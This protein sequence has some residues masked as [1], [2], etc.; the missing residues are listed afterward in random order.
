MI[1]TFN[2]NNLKAIVMYSLLAFLISCNKKDKYDPISSFDQLEKYFKTTLEQTSKALDEINNATTIEEKKEKYLEARTY[3]KSCEPLL[4]FIDSESYTYLN[5]P[6]L[7]KVEEEDFTDIKIK[8][9]TG[10]QVI[11]ENLFGE[12]IDTIALKKN[13][14]LTSNRIKFLH[15]NQHLQSLKKHHVLWII[16]DAIN[17]VALTGITG[18]DSPVLENSLTESA[19]VYKSLKEILSY[20]ENDFKDK[21]LYIAWVNQLD[22][23][24]T[25]LNNASFEKFNRFIF[26]KENTHQS[27]SL[28][29]KIVKDWKVEFPFKKAINTEASNLF[30]DKTFNINYFTD[31]K[32]NPVQESKVAL[33]KMLFN[34]SSLSNDKSISCATCH[35][36][37]M[38]FTD[39]L[40]VSPK[41]TRNS[42]TLFYAALQKGFFHDKRTGSLEGQIVDVVNNP[43]EFHL[44]LNDLEKRVMAK[45]AYQEAFKKVYTKT[46][47]NQLIR[48]AI[49]SYIMS[50]SPFNSKFDNNMQGKEN[51][52]TQSEINGFNV[53][54]GKAKCATC[55]FAPI[56]NGLIPMAFKESELELIG[57]PD[58]KDT[59]NAIIDDDLGRYGV[60]K[61]QQKKHFFKT[62]T[63]RNI[64]KT[65][66]YMHN[67]VY[68][69]LEEVIEFYNKGG[70]SGLGIELEYQTLPTDK[71]N[72][73]NQEKKDLIAF[74]KSLTD[75]I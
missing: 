58:S 53:F 26:I 6:N 14:D 4:A 62:P 28:W 74:M 69:T 42:P 29:N 64:E 25:F 52:L 38:Y 16:K 49:A 17:R 67:G 9:P 19:T 8:E 66:P 12:K 2:T 50:L 33:G 20:F 1:K 61:T 39:G 73:S 70:A 72:L 13:V 75:K 23:N 22:K 35:K 10:F 3:F 55:H 41:T 11:E 54:M 43:N 15:K 65:A 45:P 56:F 60:Y 31:Q 68:T 7:L 32:G 63:V 36:E 34:D 24:I 59:I 51:S 27:L 44:S 57:V 71:L 21:E 47:D 37:E 18:F 30:S 5:Q 48:N 46:I 40:A